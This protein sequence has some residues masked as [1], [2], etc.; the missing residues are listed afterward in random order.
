[1]RGLFGVIDCTPLVFILAKHTRM[2]ANRISGGAIYSR[3][4][5]EEKAQKHPFKL[6][7][8]GEIGLILF[9]LCPLRAVHA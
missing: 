6:S 1:M 5:A 3:N 4:A 8:T 7:I 2:N 9:T